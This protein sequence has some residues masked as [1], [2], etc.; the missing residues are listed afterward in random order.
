MVWNGRDQATR[1]D[2]NVATNSE[3][4]SVTNENASMIN[5]Y[6]R[7]IWKY[8]RKQPPEKEWAALLSGG[9]VSSL[10]VG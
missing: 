9:S 7:K 10:D 6:S 3:E 4:M 2:V 8:K 1:K 5:T